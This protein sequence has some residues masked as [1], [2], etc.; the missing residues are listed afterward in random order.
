[1]IGKFIVWILDKLGPEDDTWPEPPILDYHPETRSFT[2]PFDDDLP[3]FPGAIRHPTLGKLEHDSQ[4]DLFEV[5]MAWRGHLIDIC[6]NADRHPDVFVEN[7]E[8]AASIAKEL[9]T[10]MKR[11]LEQMV[12]CGGIEAPVD[13]SGLIEKLEYVGAY[14]HDPDRIEISCHGLQGTEIPECDLYFTAMGELTGAEI[15][16]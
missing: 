14:I 11:A 15:Q 10:W 13:T 4:F 6:I 3:A 16:D 12:L 9:D 7:L 1:M 5:E 2:P 8:I